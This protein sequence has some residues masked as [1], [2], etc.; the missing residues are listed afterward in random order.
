[1][2]VAAFRAG[3]CPDCGCREFYEGP[4]GG[5]CINWQCAGCGN[6]FNIGQ[7]GSDFMVAERI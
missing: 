7:V 5:L 3:K 2:I 4:S 1:M 6:K